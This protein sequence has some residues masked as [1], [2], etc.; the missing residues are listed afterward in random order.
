MPFLICMRVSYRAHRVP[1]KKDLKLCINLCFVLL[2]CSGGITSSRPELNSQ[3]VYHGLSAK[4]MGHCLHAGAQ[5]NRQEDWLLAALTIVKSSTTFPA[6]LC[7]FHVH[8]TH[9]SPHLDQS[10]DRVLVCS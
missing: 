2:G 8:R 5:G 4:K 10:C 7:K 1:D 9:V 3:G 6:R